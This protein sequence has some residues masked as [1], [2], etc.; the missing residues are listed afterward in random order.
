[1]EKYFLCAKPVFIAPNE[2]TCVSFR[3]HGNCLSID[4]QGFAQAIA[5]QL[6]PVLHCHRK[7]LIWRAFQGIKFMPHK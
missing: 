6:A 2:R 5:S 7:M 4:L 3:I 1:L